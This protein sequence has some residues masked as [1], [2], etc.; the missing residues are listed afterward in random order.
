MTLDRS[1]MKAAQR[2]D[3]VVGKVIELKESG[4]ELTSE[5]MKMLKEA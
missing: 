4:G 2:K 5:M 1:E 3:P